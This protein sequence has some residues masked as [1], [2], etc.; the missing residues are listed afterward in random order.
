MTGIRFSVA[1]SSTSARTA[2]ERREAGIARATDAQVA[3]PEAPRRPAA[4]APCPRLLADSLRDILNDG[5][6]PPR[7]IRIASA[8]QAF[9]AA[10]TIGAPRL[11]DSA[12]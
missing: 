6:P 12:V 9:A 2:F 4:E 11:L 3:E 1:S 8:A 10:S 5:T 7:G